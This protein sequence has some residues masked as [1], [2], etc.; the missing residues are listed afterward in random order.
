MVHIFG[1]LC[2]LWE[3][4]I[5]TASIFLIKLRWRWSRLYST[6]NLT[7]CIYKFSLSPPVSVEWAFRCPVLFLL[8]CSKR[9]HEIEQGLQS[10]GNFT[11]VKNKVNPALL[12][13]AFTHQRQV[14][15]F[16]T[17]A[18]YTPVFI[19]N[20]GIHVASKKRSFLW[21][22]WDRLFSSI[23][24]GFFGHIG[25]SWCVHSRHPSKIRTSACG[26]AED[27]VRKGKESSWWRC[28][29]RIVLKHIFNCWRN[30]CC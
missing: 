2:L 26:G 1:F 30:A 10:P 16:I 4:L 13:C 7:R 14:W 20:I 6:R 28:K 18:F 17:D 12:S 9:P 15:F 21:K 8:W 29:S 11:M 27:Q 5:L 22:C 19:V 23:C 24:G 25:L 3:P